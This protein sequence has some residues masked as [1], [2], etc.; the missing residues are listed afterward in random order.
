MRR[1]VTTLAY[2]TVSIQCSPT[3]SIFP[4]KIFTKTLLR[5]A[6]GFRRPTLLFCLL[7]EK[8]AS[9]TSSQEREGSY[10]AIRVE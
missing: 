6:Q 4:L 1:A 2:L 9:D 10:A 8:C 7:S 5:N 3:T